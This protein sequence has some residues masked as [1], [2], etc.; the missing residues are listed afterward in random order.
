MISCHCIFDQALLE[1]DNEIRENYLELLTNFYFLFES[2]YKY[3]TEL[4]KFI[5]E[6]QDGYYIQMSLETMFFDKEGKQLLVRY[7]KITKL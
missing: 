1:L 5:K 4:N 2:I 6:V 3:I 7:F